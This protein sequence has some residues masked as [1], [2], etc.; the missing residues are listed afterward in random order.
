MIALQLTTKPAKERITIMVCPQG[1][2]NEKDNKHGPKLRCEARPM[3]PEMDRFQP[4]I[5]VARCFEYGDKDPTDKKFYD[6]NAGY[7]VYKNPDASNR[8]AIMPNVKK[9]CHYQT[10]ME[11]LLQTA[12]QTIDR[13]IGSIEWVKGELDYDYVQQLVKQLCADKPAYISIPRNAV[14]KARGPVLHGWIPFEVH[15]ETYY[16][17]FHWDTQL[18]KIGIIDMLDKILEDMAGLKHTADKMVRLFEEDRAA[19]VDYVTKMNNN[20]YMFDP[21]VHD[22][23]DLDDGDE[24]PYLKKL[25]ACLV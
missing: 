23:Y 2:V 22:V 21:A 3:A 16:L 4:I 15:D 17:H 18:A 10:A 1:T 19:L 9:H 13:I 14:L 6:G 24:D 8:T 11:Q 12:K 25:M 7:D 5:T 20:K